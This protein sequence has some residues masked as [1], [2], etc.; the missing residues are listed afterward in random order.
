MQLGKQASLHKKSGEARVQIHSLLRPCLH[1]SA[2]H[3]AVLPPGWQFDSVVLGCP[4]LPALLP[5]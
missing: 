3:R 2:P 5:W 4:G 1:L